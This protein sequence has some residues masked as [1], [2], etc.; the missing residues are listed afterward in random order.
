MLLAMRTALSRF[1]PPI[2]LMGVIFYLSAQPGLSSGLS[3][4]F[5]LRKAAHMTE[6]ALLVL[7]WWR[8]LRFRRL[9]VAVGIAVL[10]AATDELHQTTVA[11]RHGSPVDWLI[12]AG[13]VLIGVLVARELRRRHRRRRVAA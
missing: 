10:Y 3:I 6:Y 11:G 12:D 7:L 4:D 13:G 1:A 8:A 5:Y 2:A 9:P